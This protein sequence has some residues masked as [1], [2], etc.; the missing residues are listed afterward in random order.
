MAFK[1]WKMLKLQKQI[2][3][4]SIIRRYGKECIYKNITM[5]IL[6]C[7]RHIGMGGVAS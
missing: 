1:R 4:E 5:M 2:F 6:G 7:E 3:L